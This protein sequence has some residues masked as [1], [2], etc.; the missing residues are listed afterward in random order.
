[1]RGN[2]GMH[3]PLWNCLE[4][5]RRSCLSTPPSL[6]YLSHILSLGSDFEPQNFE[7]KWCSNP[8]QVRRLAPQYILMDI[9]SP[10]AIFLR[11]A[12]LLW[13]RWRTYWMN[14]AFRFHLFFSGKPSMGLVIYACHFAAVG[15]CGTLERLA[16]LSGKTYCSMINPRKKMFF[17][18][19]QRGRD[20]K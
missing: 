16:S 13:R 7:W 14:A 20:R 1:M 19:A 11:A 17:I 10:D 5:S 3:I 6:V 8:S 18:R 2:W 9:A 15:F 4:F 12:K